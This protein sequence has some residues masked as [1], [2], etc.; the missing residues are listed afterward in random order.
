MEVNVQTHTDTNFTQI[1]DLSKVVILPRVAHATIDFHIQR[2]RDHVATLDNYSFEMLEV[3]PR[4]CELRK[5]FEALMRLVEG[6]QL[7]DQSTLGGIYNAFIEAW[8]AA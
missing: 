4:L 6:H 2:I 5:E 7:V 8:T 3:E 1:G